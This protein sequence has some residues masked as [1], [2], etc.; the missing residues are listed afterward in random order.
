MKLISAFLFLLASGRLEYMGEL[1]K[2]IQVD[3][4]GGCVGRRACGHH[5]AL[6]PNETCYDAQMKD[7]KFHYAAENSPCEEYFTGENII[8]LENN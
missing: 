6:V 2:H 7:Y 4:Y 5:K 8:L 3:I 1:I